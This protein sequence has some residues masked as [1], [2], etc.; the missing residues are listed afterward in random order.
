MVDAIPELMRRWRSCPLESAPYTLPGDEVLRASSKWAHPYLSLDKFNQSPAFGSSDT[1]LHLGLL[2]VPFVGDLQRA[3]V[4]IL[5]LNPG[6]A[7]I[8]YYA[9]EHSKDYRDALIRNVRQDHDGSA[10]PFVF[11]DPRFSWHEGFAYWHGRLR[12]IVKMLAHTRGLSYQAALS[13]LARATCA[14]ELLP[15]HSASFGI[16]SKVLATLASVRLVQR[17]VE[18]VLVPKARAGRAVLVVTRGASLWRVR[19]DD[20][21][22]VYSGGEPRGAYLGPKTRGG[23]AIA[24]HLQLAQTSPL[25]G[26]SQA[27]RAGQFIGRTALPP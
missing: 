10:Y 22:V 7:P 16:P 3:T 26:M 27:A 13:H 11:L 21:I 19:E 17:F 25:K 2:P 24:R 20:N 14:I 5:L 8:D 15:Y 12:G 6:F 4:Y 9:E 1:Q 23:A 18:E